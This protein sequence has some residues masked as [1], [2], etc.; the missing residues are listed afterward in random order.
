MI[1]K[2]DINNETITISSDITAIEA[3]D[4]NFTTHDITLQKSI[5]NSDFLVTNETWSLAPN[6][7]DGV[8]TISL[9]SKENKTINFLLTDNTGKTFLNKKA[10]VIKGANTFKLNLREQN[11][12]TSGTYYLNA[13][14]LDAE[15]VKKVIV[16]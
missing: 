13:K 11:R 2:T 7:T 12:L 8:I 4:G 6:P 3:V 16:R 15:K 5:S 9:L 14:G 10:E 1:P